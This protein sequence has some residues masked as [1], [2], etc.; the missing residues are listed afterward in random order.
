[1]IRIAAVADLHFGRDS[2]GALRAHLGQLDATADVLLIAGDLTRHGR[3]EEAAVLAR[4]LA[5]VK[6]PVV[7]VLGNHDY[8]SGEE[9]AITDVMQEVGVRVLEG[10]STVVEV[11]GATLGIAGI[12]GFG[13]G[14]VGAC[15][16]DFGEPE[17]KSFVRHTKQL[18]DRFAEVLGGLSSDYRVALLHYSPIEATLRG[19][20]LEIYPFLG[21]Y[22]FAEA[23]DR[24]GA[25]LVLHGHAHA[26]SARGMT[27]GRTPVRNVAL[28]VIRRPYSLF[29]LGGNGDVDG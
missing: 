8:H 1:M 29:S 20:R 18:A 24:L 14:F 17:M 2:M 21:S 19:E 7:A 11:A 13:G 6:V 26:G 4:D 25:D 22:F 23:I 5:D 12:K 9:K 27:P 10:D 15:G 3:A 16:S 28:S